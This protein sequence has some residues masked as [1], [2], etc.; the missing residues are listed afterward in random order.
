MRAHDPGLELLGYRAVRREERDL[1][2]GRCCRYRDV[3]GIRIDTRQLPVVD[4]DED[5]QRGCH[6][7]TTQAAGALRARQSCRPSRGAAVMGASGVGGYS[8]PRSDSNTDK[9]PVSVEIT[10]YITSGVYPPSDN[11]APALGGGRIAPPH[12]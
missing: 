2:A 3:L 7:S 1:S 6:T 11:A 12:H 10:G 4:A 5:P 9:Y 8:A